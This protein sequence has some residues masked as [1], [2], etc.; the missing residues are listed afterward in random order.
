MKSI[1]IP[2][3]DFTGKTVAITGSGSGIGQAA[4]LEF[5][6]YGAN[7]VVA[8]ISAAAAEE[9]VSAILAHGGSALAVPVDVSKSSQVDALVQTAVD[10]FGGLDIFLSNAGVGGEVLPLLEQSEEEFG[11]PEGRFSVRQGRRQAD[12]RPGPGRPDHLHRLHRRH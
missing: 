11:Q 5:A 7:V 2:T 3:F 6:H 9:T 10:R 8:D 12:D 1:Q 4:A